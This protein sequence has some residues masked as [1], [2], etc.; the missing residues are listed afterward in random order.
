[1]ADF[2]DLERQ[3]QSPDWRDRVDAVEAAALSADPRAPELLIRALH[4]S[5]DRTPVQAAVHAIVASRSV[6]AASGLLRAYEIADE[7]ISDEIAFFLAE[8]PYEELRW[9]VDETLAALSGSADSAVRAAAADLLTYPLRP[10]EDD[11]LLS[12]L[13]SALRDPDTTVRESAAASLQHLRPAPLIETIRQ[14]HDEWLRQQEGE[15]S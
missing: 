1:M 12:A 11:V 13:D 14:K 15:K 7:H 3:L 5:E 2:S 9:L 10:D 8:E 4:D 6:S